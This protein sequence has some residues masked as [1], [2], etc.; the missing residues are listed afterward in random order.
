MS[1]HLKDMAVQPDADGFLLSEVPLGTGMLDLPPASS[2][3]C[4]RRNPAIVFN[5]EMATRDPLKIPCLTDGY[6]VTFPRTPG[7]RTLPP[8]CER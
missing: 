8:R 1:V 5:L 3:R 6:W 4:A 7:R 2:P